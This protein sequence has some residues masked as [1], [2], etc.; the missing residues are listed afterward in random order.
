MNVYAQTFT[1]IYIRFTSVYNPTN[2]QT[3]WKVCHVTGMFNVGKNKDCELIFPTG[4]SYYYTNIGAPPDK[5]S[6]NDSC[7]Y[8]SMRCA[9]DAGAICTIMLTSCGDLYVMY[10]NKDNSDEWYAFVYRE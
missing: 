5:G 1:K 9:D 10:Y 6:L 8:T 3:E 2:S 4:K 7:T